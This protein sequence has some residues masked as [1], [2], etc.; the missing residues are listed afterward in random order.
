MGEHA[1]LLPWEGDDG[2]EEIEHHRAFGRLPFVVQTR[3]DC[4]I[5]QKNSRT[6]ADLRLGCMIGKE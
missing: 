4:V 2:N 6:S 5:I 3:L 1:H